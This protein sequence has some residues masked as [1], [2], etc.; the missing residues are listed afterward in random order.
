MKSSC[1]AH[2]GRAAGWRCTACGALLCP[3]CTLE[4]KVGST[5]T[6]ACARCHGLAERVKARRAELRPFPARIASAF[7]YPLKPGGLLSLLGLALVIRALQFV[8]LG[9]FV[10]SG[11]YWAF[12]FGVIVSTWKGQEALEPPDFS[13]V[14]DDLLVP[15]VKGLVAG[16]IVIVPFVVRAVA[17]VTAVLA[18]QPGAETANVI[19]AVLGDKL[20]WLLLLASIVYLPATLIAAALGRG[21]LAMLDPRVPFHLIRLLGGDY[22]IVTVTTALLVLAGE[23][24]GA[25]LGATVSRIPIAGGVLGRIPEIYFLVVAARIL[26]L[27]VHVRGDE[28]GMGMEEDYLEP[29]LAGATPQG[30]VVNLEPAPRRPRGAVDAGGGVAQAVTVGPAAPERDPDA[31]AHPPPKHEPEGEPPPAAAPGDPLEAALAA[32]DRALAF[33]LYRERQGARGLL[34][35]A[36]LYEVARAA[37]EA[38]EYSI[39]AHALRAAA[40][41][42]DDPAAPDA[43]LVL[44]RLYGGKLNRADAARQTFEALLARHPGTA[45]AEQARALLA[46]LGVVNGDA[47]RR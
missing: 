2:R 4:L 18:E 43:L 32:G 44:G 5:L 3:S 41:V 24:A 17:V 34:T 6:E 13:D 19:R 36:Q 38:A 22:A 12:V 31:T 8:P 10:A 14:F 1:F 39:A 40:S 28:L 46:K 23:V 27:L 7:G 42:A 16:A 9:G 15:A 11:I 20:L 26:G 33:A 37:A 21:V 29:V 30:G 35:G 25:T 47:G 45:A